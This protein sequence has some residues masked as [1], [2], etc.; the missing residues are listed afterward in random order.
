MLY[1]SPL[2]EITKGFSTKYLS[3]RLDSPAL[4]KIGC[5]WRKDDVG[6][7]ILDETSSSILLRYAKDDASRIRGP[8]V[9]NVLVD[10]CMSGNTNILGEQVKKLL[11]LR[12]GDIIVSYDDQQN[13]KPDR[14]KNIRAKGKRPTWRITLTDGSFLECTSNEKILTN[15]GWVYFTQLLSKS[16]INRCQKAR[17]FEATYKSTITS[18]SGNNARRRVNPTSSSSISGIPMLSQLQTN[19]VC[20]TPSTDSRE[21]HQHNSSFSS[22]SRIWKG[23]VPFFYGNYS[24][25]RISTYALLQGNQQQTNQDS[26]TTMA[27]SCDLGGNRVLVYGRR[28]LKS[29]QRARGSG[30][31]CYK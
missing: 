2:E 11:D 22:Q 10:E 28:K 13:I 29:Q 7:K 15:I 21:L 31:I 4:K 26:N 17:N 9:D 3:P 14:I 19:K 20:S 23:A 6:F 12:P 8:A 5:S 25:I 1:I 16:E 27:R 18:H 30:I 24:G